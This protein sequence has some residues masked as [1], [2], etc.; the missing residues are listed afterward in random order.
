MPRPFLDRRQLHRAALAWML[1]TTL[2]ASGWAQ[3]SRPSAT[4]LSEAEAEADAATDAAPPVATPPEPATPAKPAHTMPSDPTLEQVALGL[5]SLME[6]CAF[7]VLDQPA[8]LDQIAWTQRLRSVWSDGDWLSDASRRHEGSPWIRLEHFESVAARALAWVWPIAQRH[9]MVQ[10]HHLAI[11]DLTTILSEMNRH[12][13]DGRW[14]TV[15]LERR[16]GGQLYTRLL[17]EVVQVQLDWL[18]EHSGRFLNNP[19]A[20]NAQLEMENWEA[21]QRITR[22][23]MDSVFFAIAQEEQRWRTTPLPKINVPTQMATIVKVLGPPPEKMPF[24]IRARLRPE[25]IVHKDLTQTAVAKATA[26][27]SRRKKKKN[28]DS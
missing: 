11:H 26:P 5:R 15:Q 22:A 10:V 14:A 20:R 21:S 1:A 13:E 28:R 9:L 12:P 8:R 4:A 27:T 7:H 2:P 19:A 18:R 6:V 16:I 17:G 25:D 3:N 23:I 24:G